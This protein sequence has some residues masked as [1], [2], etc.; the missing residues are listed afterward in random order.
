MEIPK[1]FGMDYLTRNYMF[2]CIY[3][4]TLKIVNIEKIDTSID[5]YMYVKQ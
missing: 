1:N 2:K 4:Y 5:T 3:L